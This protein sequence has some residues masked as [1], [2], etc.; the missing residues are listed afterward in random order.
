MRGSVLL[1]AS[2]LRFTSG[3]VLSFRASEQ[4]SAVVRCLNVTLG[5]QGNGNWCLGACRI[6]ACSFKAKLIQ[7]QKSF[8]NE[9][10]GSLAS[11][12]E[13]NIFWF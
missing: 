1:G 10:N 13:M 7:I 11:F 9:C 4:M 8:V 3:F 2:E 12:L 6:M 5:K